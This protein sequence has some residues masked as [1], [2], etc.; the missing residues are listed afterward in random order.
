M[1]RKSHK[2]VD[3]TWNEAVFGYITCKIKN[4][5]I[6]WIT[7]ERHELLLWIRHHIET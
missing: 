2:A 6:F 1:Q 4:W 3:E 5:L 7:Y